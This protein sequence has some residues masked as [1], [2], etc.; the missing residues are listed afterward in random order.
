VLFLLR[1]ERATD[2]RLRLSYALKGLEAEVSY[3][4]LLAPRQ[5]TLTLEAQLAL[6]NNSKLPLPQTQVRLPSGH[7]LTASLDLGQSIQQVL[8]RYEVSA[9]RSATCTTTRGS[10]I[11]C[12]RS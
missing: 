2:C 3:T 5:Q 9:T 8:L 4:A 7:R 12:G 11:A 10:T 1:A 6:R